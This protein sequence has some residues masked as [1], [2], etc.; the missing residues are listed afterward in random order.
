MF[1]PFY[2]FIVLT[3]FVSCIA[4][5]VYYKLIYK[6]LIPSKQF[7][8][9][10]VI[11]S[12]VFALIRT[13]AMSYLS[14]RARTHTVWQESNVLYLIR[15]V[16]SFDYAILTFPIISELFSLTNEKITTTQI[17]VV[18]QE[19]LFVLVFF[20]PSIVISLIIILPILIFVFRKDFEKKEKYKG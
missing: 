15:F 16:L 6:R 19:V 10:W 13:F 1:L 5:A 4:L 3:V 20:I 9:Y 12:L 8:K 2:D 18:F 14:Y 17:S 7:I 11:S